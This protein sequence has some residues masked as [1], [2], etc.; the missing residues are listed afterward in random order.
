MKGNVQ[1]PKGRGSRADRLVPDPVI[2]RQRVV[3][4]YLALATACGFGYLITGLGVRSSLIHALTTVS[5]GGFSDR[6]DS[7]VS[8]PGGAK[9]VATV[10]MLIGGVSFF[11]VLA[12]PGKPP[13]FR[14]ES[15]TPD[16][17]RHHRG[18]DPLLLREVD[19]LSVGARSSRRQVRRARPDS[20]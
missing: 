18:G 9:V 12:A 14:K 11:A 3:R 7:F 6:A 8:A 17:P 13:S 2:G 10:F 1:I 15:R 16:L 5:T 20:L 19:G 4:L